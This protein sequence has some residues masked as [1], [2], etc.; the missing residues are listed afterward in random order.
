MG[1]K[2]KGEPDLKSKDSDFFMV[3]LSKPTNQPPILRHVNTYGSIASNMLPYFLYNCRIIESR[4][5][6]L[7]YINSA[8]NIMEMKYIAFTVYTI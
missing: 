5:I 3:P 7:Y 4:N 8:N 1:D 6:V 2:K